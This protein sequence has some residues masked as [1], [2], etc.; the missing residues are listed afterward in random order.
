MA[1][2]I[3]KSLTLN[4]NYLR[5]FWKKSQENGP[6]AEKWQ[7]RKNLKKKK[8]EKSTRQK[9]VRGDRNGQSNDSPEIPDKRMASDIPS[10]P[11]EVP[12]TVK[13]T[14]WAV[15]QIQKRSMWLPTCLQNVS[16]QEINGRIKQLVKNKNWIMEPHLWCK[17]FIVSLLSKPWFRLQ[18][19]FT[20]HPEHSVGRNWKPS[21][22]PQY[23]CSAL[24]SLYA[25]LSATF[26]LPR[27][28][29]S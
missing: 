8:K 10:L 12:V 3:Q 13:C 1:R 9:N 2:A 22:Q 14:V 28:G 29:H 20:C 21:G 23:H 16:Y 6:L 26:C 18:S 24:L 17:T 27:S 19:K 11:S 7:E 25:H 4:E 5:L 15:T